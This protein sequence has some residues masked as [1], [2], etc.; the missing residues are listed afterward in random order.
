MHFIAWGF[1]AA[2]TTRVPGGPL[3]PFR[4]TEYYTSIVT[5]RRMPKSED[6]EGAAGGRGSG[7]EDEA[8]T[9]EGVRRGL[10]AERMNRTLALPGCLCIQ[11]PRVVSYAE[12]GDP[13][14]FVVGHIRSCRI[15]LSLPPMVLVLYSVLHYV[16]LRY[17]DTASLHWRLKVSLSLPL[18]LPP[19]LLPLLLLF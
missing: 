10:A 12:V 8:D 4:H 14:G 18:P 13:N 5:L 11:Q 17:R 2:A 16:R 1:L 3:R 9:P 6:K 15:I 7:D 19:P